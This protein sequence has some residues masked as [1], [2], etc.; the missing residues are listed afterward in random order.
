MIGTRQWV[1]SLNQQYT[2]VSSNRSGLD[3]LLATRSF[4]NFLNTN[5]QSQRY[6]KEMEHDWEVIYR[7]W[8]SNCNEIREELYGLEQEIRKIGAQIQKF[9][10][11]VEEIPDED[12]FERSKHIL[13][14]IREASWY[15]SWDN[16]TDNLDLDLL[17]VE[18]SPQTQTGY[19]VS[20]V[21][22]VTQTLVRLAEAVGI[23]QEPA[24]RLR[25]LTQGLWRK[26]CSA[27]W[28][29]KNDWTSSGK[30]AF[31]Q[32]RT[33]VTIMDGDVFIDPA[34][35]KF[36]QILPFIPWITLM[37]MYAPPDLRKE[38]EYWFN[39]P[40][41]INKDFEKDIDIEPVI[42]SC[43]QQ[44][45]TELQFLANSR[46]AHRHL[47]ER[48][49]VRCENYDWKYITDMVQEYAQQKTKMAKQ[50]DKRPRY[51]FEDLLTLHFARYLHDNGYAVHYTPRDGVHEPDLLGDLSNELEPI[52][53]EAKVVG[54]RYGTEQGTP[55]IMSGLRALLSYLEKYHSD[56]GVMDGY[57]I[58]FRLG[59]ETSP[60]YTFDQSEWVIGQFTIVPMIINL[61]QLNKKD[62]PIIIRK[63]D[64]LSE[65]KGQVQSAS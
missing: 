24:V 34:N 12:N 62:P 4:F 25:R 37:A 45:F 2:T 28:K 16:E 50:A 8:F 52:V 26:Y 6:V 60:T 48:Y 33:V 63:E 40:D 54:Q 43:L 15:Q 59:D 42:K 36:P 39:Q 53:V 47:V 13:G 65:L 31:E 11:D 17:H 61:S 19:M 9:I 41:I 49:K 3:L 21:L 38:V 27:Q 58:V 44:V 23:E 32:L 57:L 29:V 55:W 30:C 18:R 64:F 35:L 51:E 22:S 5:H 20:H 14:K 1:S 56:Y 46:L 7:R 10:Q